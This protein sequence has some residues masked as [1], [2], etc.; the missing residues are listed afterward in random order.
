MIDKIAFFLPNLQGG[1][2]E[3]VVVTLAN[4]FSKRVNV[5]IVLCDANGPLLKE[6]SQ[7]V[8]L[9]NLNVK[10]EYFCLSP[11]VN[12]INKH[13]PDVFLS[14][15]DLANIMVLIAKKISGF[16][17]KIII[18]LSNTVSKQKRS[19]F[20]K[21]IERFLMKNFYNTAD[22]IIAVSNGVAKDFSLYT[23]IN[24][25]RVSVIYNPVISEDLYTLANEKI[26]HPWFVDHDLPVIL[27]VGRL[28]KQKNYPLL[29]KAFARLQEKIP[30]RLLILGE[31]NE[32]QK[33]HDLVNSFELNEYVD[34]PGFQQNPFA[35]MKKADCFVLSSDYEGLPNVLIQ[36]MACGCPVVST[37]CPSGPREI[38]GDG[39]FGYLVP[40]GDADSLA[41]SMMQILNG[42][43][44]KP[45]VDWMEKFTLENVVEQYWQFFNAPNAKK[46]LPKFISS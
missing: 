15:L 2:A 42:Q 40:V 11:L 39:K 37:D 8:K 21:K 31:G 13:S 29:I 5:D 10:N 18:R 26:D 41:F 32:R 22:V 6:C 44:L 28:T 30:C 19:F 12:Y 4:S 1:G 36:A 43:I 38:L 35:Y 25:K 20:K 46:N 16:Q 33:I 23:G 3:R 27:A 14:T 17:K 34:M 7:N 45:S 24:E 9:I